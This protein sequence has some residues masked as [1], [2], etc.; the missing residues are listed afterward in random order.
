MT[1]VAK[2]P[3]GKIANSDKAQAVWAHIL[4]IATDA[5][6]QYALALQCRVSNISLNDR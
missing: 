3:A 5:T 1:R 6:I 2:E 4:F